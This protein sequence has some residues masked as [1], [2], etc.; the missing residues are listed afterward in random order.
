MR[1]MEAIIVPAVLILGIY[2]FLVVAT[3]EKRMLA[4][5]TQP[6]RQEHVGNS[7]LSHK[8]RRHAG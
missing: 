5:K 1:W 8:Q 2:C 4:R 7:D 6:R 3:F